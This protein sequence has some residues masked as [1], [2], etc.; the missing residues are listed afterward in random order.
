MANIRNVLFILCDQ[1]RADHLSCYGHPVLHTPAIDAL[2]ERGVRFTNG[3]VQ[4]GVCGPSRM[5]YYTGRYA[6]THAS[7]WNFVPL[8][9]AERTL[10]DHLAVHGR[11]VHLIGKSH[12][13]ADHAGLR[14]RGI[15]PDS[16]AGKFAVAGGFRAIARH[17]D[18]PA[19]RKDYNNWLQARGYKGE[20]PWAFYAAAVEGSSGEV[21]PGWL[22][23]HAHLPA[24]VRAEDSE[25]AYVSD[26]AIEFI[27]T[28]RE[29]WVLHLSYI[30]PHWP[31]VAPAPYHAAFRSYRAPLLPRSS[32]P[33]EHPVI[34]AYRQL[35]ECRSF[36]RPEVAQHV[37]PAYMGLI[38]EIDR[39][40]GRVLG[41]LDESGQADETL[42]IFSSDHGDFLGDRGL[43][44]KE[45]FYDEVHKVPLIVV[46]PSPAADATRGRMEE[47]LV[48]AI[49]MLPTILDAL[50]LPAPPEWLEGHSLVPMLRGTEMTERD[51]VFSELDYS[52]R[53]V[54]NFLGLA[55]LHPCRAWMVRTRHWKYIHWHGFRPQ[56][57]DLFSD[58]YEQ[59]DLHDSALHASIRSQMRE[60]LFHWMSTLKHRAAA[61]EELIETLGHGPPAG[62]HIGQW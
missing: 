11:S 22:M 35:D 50:E 61:D 20:D 9:L 3:F 39:H 24:R 26:L 62:I 41:A 28:T 38:Q 57:F 18:T 4:S 60:R 13:T 43:G 1:L 58:K 21:L 45:L 31:Y 8:P 29:P 12:V 34:A 30:K 2:A 14:A 10:G 33:D 54:R 40:L 5:S 47:R 59:H 19:T 44:E 42:I 23:R 32:D 15:D 36:A 27:R 52:M 56:L 16:D 46:D 6:S 37:R 7:T 49:D 53:E 25:T 51:C 55:P 48:Q 17:E